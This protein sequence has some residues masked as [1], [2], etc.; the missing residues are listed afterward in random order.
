MVCAW[1]STFNT[2]YCQFNTYSTIDV[3][4]LMQG[5]IIRSY[6]SAFITIIWSFCHL[7]QRAFLPLFIL[8]SLSHLQFLGG[9]HH[10]SLPNQVLFQLQTMTV[11]KLNISRAQPCPTPQ[12][13]MV[14]MNRKMTSYAAV[15]GQ[16]ALDS[17]YTSRKLTDFLEFPPTRRSRWG[18]LITILYSKYVRLKNPLSRVLRIIEE[19]YQQ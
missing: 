10:W 4:P 17:D 5:V 12:W 1:F 14:L 9:S 8:R 16:N 13:N 3:F 2:N 6:L 18:P 7:L 19:K 11:K 15:E